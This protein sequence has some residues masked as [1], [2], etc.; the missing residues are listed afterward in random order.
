MGLIPVSWDASTVCL[1]AQAVLKWR[2]YERLVLSA[3]EHGDDIH[4]YYNM[5]SFLAKG[6]TLERHFGSPYFAYVLGVFTVLT[7]ATYVGLEMLLSEILHDKQHYK[8]CA[9]GFSGV[10]FALKVLTTSYWETG[11]RRY[12]TQKYLT[13]HKYP[14]ILSSLLRYFGLRVPGKFAVWFEL[15]AIQLM[16]P[17][18]SFVGHLAGILVGVIYT[19]GPLKFLMDLPINAIGLVSG[20]RTSRPRGRSDWG[21]GT[22]G[23]RPPPPQPNT[24]VWNDGSDIND[25]DYDEAI[26]RSY[27][28]LRNDTAPMT[29][30]ESAPSD[31][32]EI[33]R[34]RLN[35]FNVA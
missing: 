13:Y 27:E 14:E 18:A 2:E 11:H 25:A 31:P 35:R 19:Q 8:T 16:V 9:I 20:P 29:F 4:L 17:N 26:R 28:I 7:S 5:L 21:S 10:I 3:F 15:L 34:R 24:Y 33:R 12:V 30:P 6:R 22:S 1:S 23:Y 32:D